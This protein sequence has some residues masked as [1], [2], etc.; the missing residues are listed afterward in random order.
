M[1]AN[2]PSVHCVAAAGKGKI[3]GNVTYK[4]WRCEKRTATFFGLQGYSQSTFVLGVFVK[5]SVSAPTFL[6]RAKVS[7]HLLLAA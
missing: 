4:K 6:L 1:Q 3:F 5:S 7:G 2:R